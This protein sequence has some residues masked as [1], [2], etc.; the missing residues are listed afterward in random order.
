MTPWQVWVDGMGLWSPP[1]ASVAALGALLDGDVPPAAPAARPTA[2][3]LPPNE[4]RRAP[5]SVL[6]AVEV[7]AQAVGMSGH[8]AHALTCVFASAQGDQ[9]LTDSMCATLARAPDELS[10]T[11]FHNSVHNAAAGYW[12]I[13]TGCHAPASAICAGPFSAAA[14]LLEATVQVQASQRPVLLVCSDTPGSGPLGEVTGCTQPFG[15][16]LLLAP[17]RGPRSQARLQ[18]NPAPATAQAE[19]WPAPLLPWQGSNPSAA[20]LPLLARLAQPAEGLFRCQL[21]A[22]TTLTLQ[23]DMESVA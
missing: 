14:G 23:I 6:L 12:S 4:R 5:Q 16:A 8:P 18:L 1:L 19:P 20:M 9:P 10:P 2:A 3:V 17:E 15:C 22:T 13:A 21:A 11:R 7:A